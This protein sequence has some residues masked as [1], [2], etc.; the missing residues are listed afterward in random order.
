MLSLEGE[1]R[2][3]VLVAKPKQCWLW[4]GCIYRSTGYGMLK[5]QG[6]RYAAHRLAYEFAKGFPGEFLVCHGCDVRCCCN[7]R[8]L[9]LGTHQVNRADC[10]SKNRQIQGELHPDSKLTE[11]DVL[12]IRA[13]YKREYRGDF[14]VEAFAKRFCV[15][16]GTVSDA[17]RGRTWKSVK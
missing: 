16:I 13:T 6:V 8:H 10:V 15:T 11:R 2:A 9:F 5:Y 3:R 12:E 17:L 1:F 14:T 4:L 7:P